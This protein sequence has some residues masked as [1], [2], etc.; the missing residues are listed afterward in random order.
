MAFDIEGTFKGMV[1]AGWAVLKND[2]PAVQDCVKSAFLAEKDALK[3]I[4]EAR[5]KG[6][7][8][9][10]NGISD[11]DMKDQLSSEGQALEIALLSCK[12]QAKAAAQKAINAALKVLTDAINKLIP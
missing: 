11:Q 8:G 7:A 2:Y 9:D 3:A 10:P 5:L 1:D 6:A 12:V 4:A